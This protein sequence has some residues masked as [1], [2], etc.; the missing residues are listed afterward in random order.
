[1]LY[2]QELP[3]KHIYILLDPMFQ[4]QAHLLFVPHCDFLRDGM[5]KINLKKLL[6][7]REYIEKQTKI[8]RKT[9]DYIFKYRNKQSEN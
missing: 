5:E 1:M 9:W 6:Y 4:H 2:L 8:K 3:T 7:S